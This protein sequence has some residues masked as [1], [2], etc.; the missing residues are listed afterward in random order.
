MT[1]PRTSPDG[2]PAPPTVTS[3]RVTVKHPRGRRFDVHVVSWLPA[4]GW[5]CDCATWTARKPCPHV[6]LAADTIRT[7]TKEEA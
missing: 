5:A 7:A 1:A 6:A 3:V 4:M 2:I